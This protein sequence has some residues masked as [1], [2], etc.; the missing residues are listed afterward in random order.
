MSSYYHKHDKSVI[1]SRNS[2]EI[3]FQV[4]KESGEKMPEIIGS[5]SRRFL[6]SENGCALARSAGRLWRLEEH[7]SAFL[8]MERQGSQEKTPWNSHRWA[9]VWMADDR[10]EPYQNASSCRRSK[11]RQSGYGPYKRGSTPRY[12]WPWMRMVCRSE[13]LSLKVPELIAAKQSIL[14]KE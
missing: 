12:I 8:S 1:P 4:A 13:Y 5:L 9:R 3:T 2:W 10:R 7:P 14:S 6:D 11:G